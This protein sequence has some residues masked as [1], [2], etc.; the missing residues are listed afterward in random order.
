MAQPA[1]SVPLHI[2]TELDLDLGPRFAEIEPRGFGA[3]GIVYSAIDRDCDKKV[4]IK[5]ISFGDSV[6]CKYAFREVMVLRRMQHENIVGTHEILGLNGKSLD[7]ES[8]LDVG[9]LQC[10]YVVQDLLDAD[11]YNVIQSGQMR[12]EHV[13]FFMY[14]L[15]RGLKYLHSANVVHRDL[16]PSNILINCDNLMLKIGDFGLSR[17]VDPD[18]DHGGVL[19]ENMGTT[20]YRSPE[21]ILHPRDYNKAI[22]LWSAGC[23]FAE[24]LTGRPLCRGLDDLDQLLQILDTVQLQDG[25]WDEVL[26]IISNKALQNHPLKITVPLRER[27]ALFDCEAVDLLEDLLTFNPKMRLS[28]EEALQHPYLKEYSCVNDEPIALTPFHIEYENDNQP[29]NLMKRMILEEISAHETCGSQTDWSGWEALHAMQ[30]RLEAEEFTCDDEDMMMD[31]NGN[32]SP[33]PMPSKQIMTADQKCVHMPSTVVVSSPSSETVL[34]C[35]PFDKNRNDQNQEIVESPTDLEMSNKFFHASL[36]EPSGE[37]LKL[38]EIPAFEMNEKYLVEEKDRED[39]HARKADTLKEKEEE[40]ESV[41]GHIFATEKDYQNEEREALKNFRNS[42]IKPGTFDNCTDNIFSLGNSATSQP[43]EFDKQSISCF[44]SEITNDAFKGGDESIVCYDSEEDDARNVVNFNNKNNAL[45]SKKDDST[46][47]TEDVNEKEQNDLDIFSLR[48]KEAYH[49]QEKQVKPDIAHEI[50]LKEEFNLRQKMN[51]DLQCHGAYENQ[52][53]GIDMSWKKAADFNNHNNQHRNKN[54]KPVRPLNF[55]QEYNDYLRAS[56]TN[57]LSVSRNNHVTNGK[58]RKNLLSQKLSSHVR[59]ENSHCCDNGF[60]MNHDS[61]CSAQG[62]ASPNS[63]SMDWILFGANSSLHYPPLQVPTSQ[64]IADE[65][66]DNIQ[67]AMFS[68]PCAE[69][70]AS[71]AHPSGAKPKKFLRKTKAI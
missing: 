50:A 66:I 11:L 16:K 48:D 22:D 62:P 31:D 18:Y 2:N 1:N 41:D 69:G 3:N 38:P 44:S 13:K 5:R 59:H 17:V 39:H 28:A 63:D 15:L 67:S 55:D 57:C 65:S 27:L 19:T 9:E 42:M 25:D 71:K 43:Q 20:W 54:R 36:L 58:L 8:N 34:T 68:P 70:S 12:E 21:Q 30:T 40:V 10:V 35:L 46:G 60:L 29:V 56:P 26:A 7:C 51:R 49:I 45:N 64:R 4:A 61:A 32:I 23:I 37:D 24:M 52:C 47:F 33:V 53:T 14:Q 6:S